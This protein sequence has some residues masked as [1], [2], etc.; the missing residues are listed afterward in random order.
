VREDQWA[1]RLTHG[2]VE[3]TR[4]EWGLSICGHDTWTFKQKA[5]TLNQSLFRSSHVDMNLGQWLKEYYTKCM[6][7]M[8]FLRRVCGML[9]RNKVRS[10]RIH[11]AVK[12]KPLFRIERFQ[13]RWFAHVTRMP[14]EGR[15][16]AKLTAERLRGRTR[17]RWT[18]YIFDFAWCR[19]LETAEVSETAA[20][21]EVCRITELLPRRG[22]SGY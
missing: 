17:T 15:L 16:L 9:L 6:L 4:S 19:L 10:C 5:L 22:K 1:R 3:W 13:L 20:D 11:K 2:F 21:H 7:Q 18:D 12:V 14:W 8:R